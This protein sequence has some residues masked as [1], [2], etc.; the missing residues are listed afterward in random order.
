VKKGDATDVDE[1][2]VLEAIAAKGFRSFDDYLAA[3]TIRADGTTWTLI[4]MADELGMRS[5][6][7]IG[8][9]T[10]WIKQKVAETE[11]SSEG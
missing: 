4:E 10:R 2:R 7:F 6:T 11:G 1:A 8:Y 3:R 9:H 5:V